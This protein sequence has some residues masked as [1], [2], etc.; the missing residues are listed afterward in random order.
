MDSVHTSPTLGGAFFAGLLAEVVV[1]VGVVLVPAFP[2]PGHDGVV[3]E[4]IEPGSDE[5]VAAAELVIEEGE[6]QRGV[7][8]FDPEGEAGQLDG[9]GVEIDP[10]EAVLDD[11]ALQPGAEAGFVVDGAEADFFEQALQHGRERA[12]WWRWGRA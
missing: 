5:A 12:V 10:V 4:G 3:L 11:E 7:H 1:E 9:E 8:G 2:M 6:G